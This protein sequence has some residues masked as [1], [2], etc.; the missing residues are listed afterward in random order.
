[1]DNNELSRVA[2][3]IARFV[4]EEGRVQSE[5]EDWEDWIGWLVIEVMLEADNRGYEYPTEISQEAERLY[6]MRG[7]GPAKS[8]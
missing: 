1:M 2:T 5:S 7:P 3:E 8:Q 4:I 6:R